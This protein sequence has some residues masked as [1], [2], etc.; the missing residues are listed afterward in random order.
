MPSTLDTGCIPYIFL[1]LNIQLAN[2]PPTP[3]LTIEANYT[4]D[5]NS[6]KSPYSPLVSSRFNATQPSH[7]PGNGLSSHR[8]SIDS[9][10]Q[11]VVFDPD[12]ETPYDSGASDQQRASYDSAQ[13]QNGEYSGRQLPHVTSF[14]PTQGTNGCPILITL[15]TDYDLLAHPAPSLSLSFANKQVFISH[16]EL[17][18]VPT[19]GADFQWAI[20]IGAP[21]F[22]ETESTRYQVA[23]RLHLQEEAGQSLGSVD[24]GR[25]EYMTSHHYQSPQNSLKRKMSDEPDH[26][27]PGRPSYPYAGN[28]YQNIHSIDLDNAN[29]RFTPFGRAQ[30]QQRYRDTYSVP[31]ALPSQSL[32]RSLGSQASAWN[33]N[34]VSYSGR[35]PGYPGETQTVSL[36]TSENTP[37]LVRTTALSQNGSPGGNPAGPS[38]FNPYLYPQKALLKIHGDLGTMTE[39][40]TSDEWAAKRRLVVFT[41]NQQ[42]S[43]INATFAPVAPEDRR[44]DSICVSC[45][46]WEE[47]QECFATSVD[48]ISLLESLVAMRFTVEEKNR[49]RR[50]LEGFHPET[51]SKGKAD[52]EEFF[53]IIM[54]FPN[55][56][57]RNIEKDVKVFPWKILSHAL[58]KIISKYV[59]SRALG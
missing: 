21:P 58:K 22:H 29:R 26:T 41:R 1:H 30:H 24:L 32:M 23:V 44:P 52:S 50:N 49:I 31:A 15:S 11:D 48:T 6:N 43:T 39:N 20:S 27:T 8:A 40:W 13:S 19:S 46:W 35:S 18:R 5:L 59:S 51:V 12:S 38:G 34:L 4:S 33:P 28:S 37:M 16:N 42:K 56:K 25:F 55:P 10:V 54:A 53:K 14:N 2:T 36:S 9:Q 45:I 47:R 57:P 17:I 7:N 3:R